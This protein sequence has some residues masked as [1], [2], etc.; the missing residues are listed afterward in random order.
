LLAA[1]VDAFAGVGAGVEAADESLEV[2][3]PLLGFS[4]E[5]EACGD[6]ALALDERLLFS[7][8]FRPLSISSTS[9]MVH[10]DSLVVAL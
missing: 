8:A 9:S 6:V 4:A 2:L 3:S 1:D 7:L 10:T 5:K